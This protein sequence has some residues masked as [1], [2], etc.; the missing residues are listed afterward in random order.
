MRTDVGNPGTLEGWF[1]DDI[2]QMNGCGGIVKAGLYNS[3]NV[4][5]DSLAVPVFIKSN[6]VPTTILS[7]PLSTAACPGTNASFTVSATGGT[8][9]YQ[10]QVSTNG[11][12]SYNDIPGAT[13][14]TLNLTGV[15]AAMNGNL[16]RCVVDNGSNP[17]T[18][19]SGQLTVNSATAVAAI[20]NVTA[21]EGATALFNSNATGGNLTYQ[22][23]S[24]SDGVNF[25]NIG[26]ATS[27]N[28]S[29]ANTTL[30]QNGLKYRV[31]VSG[32]CG[33]A[34][35][36][37]GT[38]TI[39]SRPSVSINAAP[40]DICTGDAA[41]TLSATQPGGTW[42]GQGM[43]GAQFTPGGLPAGA[44]QVTYSL[45]NAAG[46]T[47]VATAS[48]VVNDCADKHLPL[49]QV[50]AIIIPT[51]SD[52]KFFIW[53]KTDLY[54]KLSMKVFQADGKLVDQ[55]TITGITY[56]MQAPVNL[57]KLAAG[58]YFLSLYDEKTDAEKTFRILIAR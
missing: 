51:P 50:G 46:C 31:V 44:Y 45:T 54:T 26:G 8:L 4:K 19:V 12:A 52:G 11:G 22:W 40:T 6:G 39:N 29:L 24:S 1:I 15:T 30:A 27:A 47:T 34:T 36:Q 41:I 43:N 53:F 57:R 16:Y 56:D 42:S 7:Q 25:T 28:L 20:A 17:A 18:S 32:A 33:N 48:V 37:A 3:S 9:T 35:S 13:A 5:I 23:Q 38:L 10:W 55:R 2:M 21:C 14:A 49:G 58:I